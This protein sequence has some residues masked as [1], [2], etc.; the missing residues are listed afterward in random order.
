MS[1][2]KD[3][4]DGDAEKN[5]NLKTLDILTGR[6]HVLRPPALAQEGE[7]EYSMGRDVE[8]K[9]Q[10]HYSF[11]GPSRAVGLGWVGAPGMTGMIC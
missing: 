3:Y 9:T 8:S 10:S 2:L 7:T 4:D 6:V 1:S 5:R 11:S